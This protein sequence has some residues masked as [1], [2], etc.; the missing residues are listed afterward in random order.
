MDPIYRKLIFF[1]VLFFLSLSLGYGESEEG[2]VK[3]PKS[4]LQITI[5][6]RSDFTIAQPLDP[7]PQYAKPEELKQ[8]KGKKKKRK[9][10]KLKK[11]RK[12]LVQRMMSLMFL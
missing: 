7:D 3:V 1:A 9:S 6:L 5:T 4:P 11:K 8:G 10:K 12:T 2:V